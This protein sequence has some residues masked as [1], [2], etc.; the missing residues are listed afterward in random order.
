MSATRCHLVR[1]KAVGPPPDPSC[2]C[3][4]SVPGRLAAAET[5]SRL[6]LCHCEATMHRIVPTPR[7]KVTGAHTELPTL[8]RISANGT[9][10]QWGIAW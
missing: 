4:K 2:P 6:K 5:I 10:G 7:E 1:E 8:G 3:M 9:K